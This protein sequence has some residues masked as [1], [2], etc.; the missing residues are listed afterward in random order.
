MAGGFRGWG[1]D[2]PEP[3]T[4]LP[5]KRCSLGGVPNPRHQ[6]QEVS[7]Q[8][9]EHGDSETL[10]AIFCHLLT[11]SKGPFFLDLPGVCFRLTPWVHLGFLLGYGPGLAPW[12]LPSCVSSLSPVRGIQ[13]LLTLSLRASC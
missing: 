3:L 4:G 2:N 10:V 7:C 9:S 11:A 1:A 8:L 6:C 5:H 13:G 12:V